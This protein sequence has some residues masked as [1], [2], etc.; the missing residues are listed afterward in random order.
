VAL[1]LFITTAAE[2][3]VAHADTTLE[4][5]EDGSGAVE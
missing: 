5:F 4:A 3:A 1:D 2:A